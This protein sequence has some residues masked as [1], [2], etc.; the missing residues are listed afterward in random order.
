MFAEQLSDSRFSGD[1]ERL[2]R[3]R[4]DP[5][6]A[7]E[8][9]QINPKLY[10]NSLRTHLLSSAVRVESTLLPNINQAFSGIREKSNISEPMEAY[11]HESPAIN[12]FVARGRRYVFVVLSSAA[13]TH[14]SE[15]ELSFV[16][17]HEMG[18]AMFGHLDFPTNFLLERG[19]LSASHWIQ[20][21]A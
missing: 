11:V 9:T 18:H 15:E 6:I 13:V 14:L 4:N 10:Q 1:R 8:L 17:G 7:S 19:S 21:M 5:D 2:S 12:A 20:V 16:I 3:L